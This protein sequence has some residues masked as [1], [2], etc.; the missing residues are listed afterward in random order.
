M[1]LPETDLEYTFYRSSGPGGQKKNTTDSAVRLHHLP[2]GIVVTATRSR[3]QHQN[4]LDAL[5]EL[6][7]RLKARM[8]RPRKRLKTKP[9]R[10]SVQRRLQ[11]KK[12]RAEQKERRR[13][14]DR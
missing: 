10:A 3:S 7:R 8:R 13:P 2:T 14:P 1:E 12:H 9:T 4:R 11:G 6:E 5:A